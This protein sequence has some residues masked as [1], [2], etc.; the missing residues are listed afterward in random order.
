MARP[1][2]LGSP[3]SVSRMSVATIDLEALRARFAALGG[4]VALFDAPGGTQVPESVVEAMA[5]YLRHTNANLG[6]PFPSSRASDLI[7]EQA[8]LAAA[9]F[10]G[11]A[12]DEIGFGASMTSLN[13]SLTRALGRELRPGD[14][15]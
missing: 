10:L 7:V 15:I 9:A 8:H 11:A 1:P 5:G 4:P 6:G 3:G 13:F 12:P 2:P 14:E